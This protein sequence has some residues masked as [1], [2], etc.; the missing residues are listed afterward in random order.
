MNKEQA[1]ALKDKIA[2]EMPDGFRVQSC[3]SDRQDGT[4]QFGIFIVGIDGK[5]DEC[6]ISIDS[7]E[8]W[9]ILK[10]F[11]I[12]YA[13]LSHLRFQKSFEEL[14]D[15]QQ[16][17]DDGEDGDDM[18]HYDSNSFDDGEGH[19]IMIAADGSHH[20]EHEFVG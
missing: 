18:S 4:Y 19:K 16:Q 13:H 14:L 1:Q 20:E 12:G 6:I 17:E 7:H 15:Q 8:R 10:H 3:L 9:L 5:N 11:I 2:Q